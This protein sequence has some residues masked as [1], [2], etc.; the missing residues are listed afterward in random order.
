[1]ALMVSEEYVNTTKGYRFGEA[2]PYEAY[3][4]DTGRLFR[5]MRREYGRC[6]SSVYV[7]RNGKTER[8]GWVFSKRMK[9]EDARGND[10]ERDYYTR[11]VWVTLHEAPDTVTRERHYHAV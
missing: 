5:D 7:D 11:E 2:E 1:M 8:V 10:R 9:Y 6:I 3:T 4:D